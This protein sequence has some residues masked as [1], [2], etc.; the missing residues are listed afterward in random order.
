MAAIKNL[1]TQ[2]VGTTAVARY[3]RLLSPLNATWATKT[4]SQA[5]IRNPGHTWTIA[6]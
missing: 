3:T 1:L 2:N 6:V 5:S 4:V